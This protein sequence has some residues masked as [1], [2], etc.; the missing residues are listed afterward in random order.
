M[1]TLSS[2]TI[3]RFHKT[4]YDHYKKYGRSLP[5]RK[6]NDPYKIL[7]S[8][9]MLQQ[10]QVDRVIPKY[11]RWL[12]MFP[13]FPTLAKAPLKKILTKWQG[14]GY[15]RRAIHLKKLAEIIVSKHSGKLPSSIEELDSLPGIGP[16]T[17]GS[18]AAFAFNKPTIFIETNIRSVFIHYFFPPK[19]KVSDRSILIKN[20]T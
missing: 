9:I 19:K 1:S 7:V 5:W 20:A 3:S 11:E 13:N 12:K 6:T 16:H 4:I 15:N 17:A 18:I 10:T 8:E 2:T 14:L